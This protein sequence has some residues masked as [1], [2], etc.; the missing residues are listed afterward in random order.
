[1]E[2]HCSHEILVGC[3]WRKEKS[4]GGAKAQS[5]PNPPR[6]QRPC[7]SYRHTSELSVRERTLFARTEHINLY[8]VGGVESAARLTA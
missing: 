4:A 3:K 1:M 8:D 7:P 6:L 5:A 2:G